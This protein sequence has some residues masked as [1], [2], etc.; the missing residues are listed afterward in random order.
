M[1]FPHTLLAL[2]AL[3]ISAWPHAALAEDPNPLQAAGRQDMGWTTTV[4]SALDVADP[5]WTTVVYARR[6]TPIE[7]ASLPSGFAPQRP[8][9]TGQHHALDGIAS[10]YWQ[11]QMTASGEVFDKRAMT[12]AHP[13]LPL[14][15]RVKVTNLDNGRSAILRINDRG[16]YVKGRVIDVS[17]AAADV[18]GMR[19]SG[20]A[21]VRV[22]LVK[23]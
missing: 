3:G 9:L 13:T 17:E 23:N 19:Q 11:D 18:L 21:P 15:S 1:R 14:G 12:A 10:Y 5:M 4:T 6:A 20:L 8:S 16:P 2:A 7:T 22:D